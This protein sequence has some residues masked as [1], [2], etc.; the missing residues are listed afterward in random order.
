MNNNTKHYNFPDL[1]HCWRIAESNLKNFGAS[2]QSIQSF[3]AFIQRN[4]PK[5][6]YKI[7]DVNVNIGCDF[8]RTFKAKCVNVV[9]KKPVMLNNDIDVKVPPEIKANSHICRLLKCSLV[10]P[11]YLKLD[12]YLDNKHEQ[13]NNVLLCYVPIMVGSDLTLPRKKLNITDDSYFIL[14]GSEKVIVVQ[15]KKIDKCIVVTGNKCLYRVP[16]IRSYWWLEKKDDTICICSKYGHC[17]VAVLFAHFDVPLDTIYPVEIRDETK[18]LLE[19]KE[20]NYLRKNFK[21]VFPKQTSVN[22]KCLFDDENAKNL[23][24]LIY[25]CYALKHNLDVYDRDHISMKRIEMPSD[26]LL[27]IGEKSLKR[28]VHSFQRRMLT[29][30]EKYPHRPL[31]KGVAR[32]IDNRVVTE[33]F[34]YALQTGNWVAAKGNIG[35]R[36]GVCQQRSNYNFSSILAQSRRFK[37]GDERRSIIGQ[38]EVHGSHRGYLCCYD[39]AEGKSCGVNKHFASLTNVSLYFDEKIVI[40]NILKEQKIQI[41]EEI[42]VSKE[43]LVFVNG[44]LICQLVDAD[45]L[46]LLYRTM[47]QYRRVGIF[48]RGISVYIIKEHLYIR[49]DAGRLLRPLFVVDN[50]LN[51]FDTSRRPLSDNFKELLDAG[52]IEYVDS[53]E[54]DTLIVAESMKEIVKGKHALCE[55]HPCLFLSLNTNYGCVYPNHNQGKLYF[56][57]YILLLL[58]AVASFSNQHTCRSKDH[59]SGCHAETIAIHHTRKF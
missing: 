14:N 38:R 19:E 56:S 42:N 3:N 15:E 33:S 45:H 16:T 32:A 26:L 10:S 12:L 30:I 25:M 36:T 18:Y 11:I 47:K 44:L 43:H 13:I 2:D 9:V 17:W 28:V 40:E 59:V 48:D 51:H 23:S 55:I 37:S 57:T 49:T 6:I 20:P 29:Y 7:F 24:Q 46:Y 52:I 50:L 31:I 34:F 35:M 22:L 58:R 8:S 53:Q 21:L 27:A 5:A 1:D 41:K 54:E 4:F 39:T